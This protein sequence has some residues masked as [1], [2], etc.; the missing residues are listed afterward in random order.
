MTRGFDMISGIQ[1]FNNDGV[2]QIDSRNVNYEYVGRKKYSFTNIIDTPVNNGS[3]YAIGYT[4]KPIGAT[5]RE[6]ML[7]LTPYTDSK[8]GEYGNIIYQQSECDLFEFKPTI[9]HLNSGLEIFSENGELVFNSN[10]KNMRIVDTKRRGCPDVFTALGDLNG[11]FDPVYFTK[12]SDNTAIV[13]NSTREAITYYPMLD[14]NHT[15]L[16]IHIDHYNCNTGV[17][18]SVINRLSGSAGGRPGTNVRGKY[19][20]RCVRDNMLLIDVTGYN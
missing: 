15:A 5:Y 13:I 1:V 10:T 16:L 2:S 3:I 8:V 11:T 9:T 17:T 14:I 7:R 20:E 4:S 12:Q 6:N 19:I 18:P